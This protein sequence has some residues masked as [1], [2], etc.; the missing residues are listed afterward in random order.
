MRNSGKKLLLIK[1]MLPEVVFV[2]YNSSDNGITERSVTK[3][4]LFGKPWIPSLYLNEYKKYNNKIF[5][6]RE[7]CLDAYLD[8][9][10]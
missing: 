2:L 8:N 4:S 9:T 3:A 5:N 6:L 7:F 1:V 10:T